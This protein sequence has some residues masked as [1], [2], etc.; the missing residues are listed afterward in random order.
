MDTLSWSLVQ[1]R[2]RKLLGW[3]EWEYLLSKH[4]PLQ[5][6]LASLVLNNRMVLK[7]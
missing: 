5:D 1:H 7:R 4:N 2:G 6:H 3:L